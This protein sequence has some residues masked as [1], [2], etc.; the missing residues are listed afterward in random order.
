MIIFLCNGNLFCFHILPIKTLRNSKFIFFLDWDLQKLY[1][2][3]SQFLNS[4]CYYAPF[5]LRGDATRRRHL[6]FTS[7][8]STRTRSSRK[9]SEGRNHD[10]ITS[11]TNSAF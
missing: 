7:N 5:F 6:G 1:I 8:T 9:A 2:P 3:L 11:A 10:P 4:V